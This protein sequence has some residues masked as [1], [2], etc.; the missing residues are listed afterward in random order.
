MQ[1]HGA[2]AIKETDAMEEQVQALYDTQRGLEAGQ[3]DG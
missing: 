3:E 2:R 1:V